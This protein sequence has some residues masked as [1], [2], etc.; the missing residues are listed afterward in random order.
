MR[1]GPLLPALK[2]F[3]IYT[4]LGLLLCGQPASAFDIPDVQPA[5]L[6]QPRINALLRRAPMGAPLAGFDIIFGDTIFNFQAFYD[7]GTSGTVLSD[8]T[9]DFLGV[10]RAQFGGSDVMF[11]DVGVGGSAV[12]KVSEPL[13]IS[14]APFSPLADINNPITESDVYDQT[15][16]PLRT[17]VGGNVTLLG[18]I[19]ILGMPTM[20]G[21]V[22]V[23]DPKP[24]DTFFDLLR[25]YVYDPGTPFDVGQADTN[26]GIPA[27]NRHVQLSYAS[28]DRFTQTTP[29]GAEG[30]DLRHNP[31]IGPNPVAAIDPAIPPGSTPGVTITL[32][33]NQATGSFLLD[34]G[35]AASFISGSLAETINVRYRPDPLGLADPLLEVFDPA[36]PGTAGTPLPNQFLITIGGIGGSRLAA[37]FFLDSLSMPTL[38]GDPINYINAPVLVVDISV[39][40]PLTMDMLILD[41]V[42]GMNFLV[43]SA[44]V[45]EDPFSIGPLSTGAFDWLVFD[46]P[47]GVLGLQIAGAPPVVLAP[48]I[49]KVFGTDPIVI[50]G[51]STLSLTITNPNATALTGAAITD[52]YPTEITNATPSNAATTCAGGVVTA[53]DGG[54]GVALNGATIPANDSCTI[55]ID[56]TSVVAGGAYL[57][58]TSSVTSVEAPPSIVADDS[59]TVNFVPAITDPTAGT[60]LSATSVS[61]TWS[62]NNNSVDQYQLIMGSSLGDDDLFDSTPL[63]GTQLSVMATLPTDGRTLF[64]RFSYQIAGVWR[65]M[66][67]QYTAATITSSPPPPGDLKDDGGSSKCFIATAA[68]GT[69]MANEV[70]YLRAFRDHYLSPNRIGRRFVELYYH[71]SPPIADYIRK[72]EWLRGLVRVSLTPLVVLSQWSVD[73]QSDG[74]EDVSMR[75]R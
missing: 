65:S 52:T 53:I 57:N 38:E 64:A 12:F 50:G 25:T 34:T 26:P 40:D 67:V 46:E 33:A 75:L 72:R 7:T 5:A 61:F 20:Q 8:A 3:G 60:T 43:A 22:V 69:P 14:L 21:K 47:N 29:A 55:T 48:T 41:G 62:A 23:I 1:H 54:S 28:F 35:A 45:I 18:G 73:D 17:Q 44:F 59:L 39:Q 63:P 30:P 68:Y 70:R 71:Y 27:T 31:F 58:T 32:G 10:Q 56:V 15:F 24:L 13:Y 37:G 9:A 6:D 51:V 16:G 19:D 11:E 66:D 42:F 49:T 74:S 4:I 36:D 2:V